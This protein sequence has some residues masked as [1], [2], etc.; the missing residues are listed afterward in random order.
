MAETKAT[1]S[2]CCLTRW[3]FLWLRACPS[4]LQKPRNH[5]KR[6]LFITCCFQLP[7]RRRCR[8]C[9]SWATAELF[10]FRV[11]NQPPIE[12]N[13]ALSVLRTAMPLT[14][15]FH[16]L[17]SSKL[18]RRRRQRWRRQHFMEAASCENGG[19]RLNR[20]VIER[21]GQPRAA[22]GQTLG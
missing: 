12:L 8:T 14:Q 5:D 4:S 22:A 11:C 16:E 21:T 9:R 3:V 18:D 17:A 2:K 7:L 1:Q 10:F 6:T 20:D 13:R 19:G 15:R